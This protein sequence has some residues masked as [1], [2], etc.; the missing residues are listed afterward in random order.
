MPTRLQL[1]DADV[2][3][4]AMSLNLNLSSKEKVDVLKATHTCDIQAGPGTGKTTT[5]TA[6]LALLAS[7]WHWTDQGILVLSHTNVARREIEKRLSE[8]S[9]LASL[10]H[11]PHFVGTFQTFVDQY[12]ALPYL[13]QGGVEIVAIDNEKFVSRALSQF[14]NASFSRARYALQN[15]NEGLELIV[16]GLRFE[17][18]Q[19]SIKS[20]ASGNKRFPGPQSPTVGQLEQLKKRLAKDGYFRFEDMYAFTEACIAKRDYLKNIVRRR[21]PW[22]F[23]DELQDTNESQDRILEALFDDDS[24]IVQRFGDK[25]QAIFQFDNASVVEPELF[26]RRPCLQLSETHRFGPEI[27]QFASAFTVVEPQTLRSISSE[28]SQ[29]RHTVFI[30]DRQTI[31]KV[32]PAFAELVI[33]QVPASEIARDGVCILGGRRIVK[34]PKDTNFPEAI[35]D[36]WPAF[37]KLTS[38]KHQVPDSLLG[39]V[40]E[41]RLQSKKDGS[42]SRAASEIDGAAIEAIRRGN[43]DKDNVSIKSRSQLYESLKELGAYNEFRQISWGFLDPGHSLSEAHWSDLTN[44][45]IQLLAPLCDSQGSSFRDFF[46]WNQITD[47]DSD[48]GT[49]PEEANGAE[50]LYCSDTGEVALRFES[51]HGAKGETHA[52]TLVLETYIKRTHDLK[53]LLPVLTGTKSATSLSVTGIEHCK[54]LF[55]GITRPRKLACLAIFSEHLDEEDVKLLE[56]QGWH[57]N[58]LCHEGQED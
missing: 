31:S 27:A 24:C 48:D 20:P 42:F 1:S 25:N 23:V 58:N 44:Q 33:K 19:L 45:L 30:F 26:G 51:I 43:S 46:T 18:E 8:H 22:V 49:E 50:F 3:T 32:V 52:A 12:F 17:G 37:L 7:K 29:S 36:Y 6:K 11:Y 57:V 2:A 5:L 35:G 54:R 9:Q 14:Q 38:R 10:L 34:Q 47:E 28:P 53:T 56:S 55:V 16:G 40:K 41:A 13:R 4:I 39:F 21:F 15:R